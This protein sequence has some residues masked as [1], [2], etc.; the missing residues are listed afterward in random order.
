MP[1]A[2]RGALSYSGV[3]YRLLRAGGGGRHMWH[4]DGSAQAV[5]GSGGKRYHGGRF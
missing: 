5:S 3:N 2:Q 1:P 4:R